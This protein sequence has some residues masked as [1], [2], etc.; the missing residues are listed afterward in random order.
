MGNL[1]ASISTIRIGFLKNLL[2][3]EIAETSMRHHIGRSYPTDIFPRFMMEKIICFADNLA[4]GADRREEPIGISSKPKFPIS[5]SHVLSRGDVIREEFCPSH[6][7]YI[8]VELRDKIKKPCM[9]FSSNS[10]S[11]YFRIFK[12]LSGS[13][14]KFVPADTRSPVND[15]SLWDHLKLTAAFSTCIHLDGKFRSFKPEDYRFAFM[16][17]GS[18]GIS[19]SDI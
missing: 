15:V 14:L 16:F 5:L 11:A 9:E 12:I 7:A 1:G 19:S 18:S 10:T 2:G 3:E 4:S 8:S 6:L 17:I 13:R